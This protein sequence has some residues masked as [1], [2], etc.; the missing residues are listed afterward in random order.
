MINCCHGNG[1]GNEEGEHMDTF[2]KE[3]AN[4]RWEYWTYDCGRRVRIS[5]AWA[6]R[7]VSRGT[8]KLIVVR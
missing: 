3:R 6:E 4:G 5:A 2:Y 1:A 8:A 7:E